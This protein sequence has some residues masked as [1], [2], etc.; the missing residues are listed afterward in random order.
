[1]LIKQAK[2]VKF[3]E[4]NLEENFLSLSE[5]SPIKKGIKKAIN[6]LKEN[7]FCGEKIAKRLIPREY[8]QKYGVDNLWRYPLPEGVE[9][10]LFN[11]S[12]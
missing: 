7:V 12:K 6:N 10:S 9:I 5:K 11:C 3:V 4:Q 2:E 8:I 1:M